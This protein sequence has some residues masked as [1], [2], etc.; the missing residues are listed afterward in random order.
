MGRCLMLNQEK[1]VRLYLDGLPP[2]VIGRQC[3]VTKPPIVRVLKEAKVPL[4]SI[5]QAM[6]LAHAQGRASLPHPRPKFS[7]EIDLSPTEA[8]Y[9]AGIID[10]E[11]SISMDFR[12]N[13]YRLS[14]GNTDKALLN[15]IYDRLGGAIRLKE[16]KEG[17]KPMYYW[18]CNQMYIVFSILSAVEPYLIVKKGKAKEA[19]DSLWQRIR[20]YLEPRDV[21]ETLYGL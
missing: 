16:K 11:G 13:T 21:R 2:A 19:F 7:Y 3:G 12:R 4:R 8:A 17:R 1:I 10:G 18:V 6:K 9:L 15:W 20:P 14:I 5:S